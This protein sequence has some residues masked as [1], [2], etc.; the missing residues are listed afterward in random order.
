MPYLLSFRTQV[1]GLVEEALA[2]GDTIGTMPE[3]QPAGLSRRALFQAGGAA[4]I[5]GALGSGGRRNIADPKAVP[6]GDLSKLTVAELQAGL[7]AGDWSARSLSEACL[8]RIEALDKGGPA[9]NS[10]IE[11][12]PDA[13]EIAEALDAER[14]SG[15]TRG[16]LHGLPVLLKDNIDTADRM[17]TTAGSLALIDSGVMR[18]AHVTQR[19]RD[20]GLVLLGKTNLSEW[21]NFRSRNSISGWSAR[22]GFT[23]NPHVLDRNPCGSSSGSAVAVAAGLVPL[24]IG[25]E[26]NGSIVCP[27]SVNGVVGIKPTVGLAGRSGIIPISHTQDTAGPMARCVADAAALLGAI[28]GVDPQDP[29]TADADQRAHE[30]YTR[31]LDPNALRGARI[32][33]LRGYWGIQPAM[34]RLLDEALATLRDAGA[35]VV[36]IPSLRGRSSTQVAGFDVLLYE[37]RPGLEKYLASLGPQARVRTLDDIIRFNKEHPKEEL[38]YFGQDIMLAAAAMGPLSDPDYERTLAAS[39]DVCRNAIDEALEDLSLDA[40]FAPT[41][42]TAWLTDR[43][44]GDRPDFRGCGWTPA[45]AGYPHITVPGGF[46]SE[47]P[48]G[49]SFFGT[50][51]SEPK[52]IGLAYSFEQAT[53]HRREP[54]FL[55]TLPISG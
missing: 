25:T 27:S 3:R 53:R 34:D 20:A 17:Q 49:V 39:R 21:A 52:L 14:E 26:T 30:D 4:A 22:G 12:N 40:L 18:D 19:L 50:A 29:A 1:G 13:L 45:Q 42:G 31:F 41:M 48:V 6:E 33:A 55:P 54:R 11:I 8:N 5:A 16:P 44:N 24:A 43:V 23:L 28:A 47:L 36:D 51:W 7:S 9:L 10:L 2:V 15:N 32:G 38:P 37:F 35:T 46:I